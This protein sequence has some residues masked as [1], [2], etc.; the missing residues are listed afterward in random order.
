MLREQ[1][2]PGPLVLFVDDVHWLDETSA[3]LLA[4]LVDADLVFLVG[5]VRADE[6][7][8]PS[9]AALWL[10]ARVRRVDLG[11]LDKA[12]VDTLL[13][14]V[15]GGPVT[16]GTIA[17]IWSASRGN[18]LFVRELVLGALETGRLVDEHGVW[19][20]I[21]PL[22][23]TTRLLELVEARVGDLGP[24]ARAAL[25]V[26]AVWEPTS[27]RMLESVVDPRLLETLDRS[28]L[29]TT[30]ADGRRDLV[31]L[32]HP[33]YGEILR[34]R[35]PLLTR[36]RLLLDQAERIEALGARRRDDAMR[37]ASARVDAAAPADARLLLEAARLARWAHDYPQVERLARA[38][39][40]DGAAPEA[41]LLLGEALH[42]LGSFEEAERVLADAMQHLADADDPS[43]ADDPLFV[44]MT[45]LR[46]RT[47]MWGLHRRADAL[48][49]SRAA[50]AR[51]ADP[52]AVDELVLNEAIL[53]GYSGRPLDA[54]E[55]VDSVADTGTD[56]ARVRTL[57][58]LAEVPTL[59]VT[60]RPVTG[61]KRARDAFA[62]HQLLP[63]QMAITSP[64]VH[65]NHEIHALTDS[66]ALPRSV[67]DRDR[68]LPGAA[69][70][71]A[72]RH[73]DVAH[74]HHRPLH[75]PARRGSD[76][77]AV[78]GR[79]DPAVG[80]ARHRRPAP[81]RAVT[82]RDRARVARRRGSRRGR[83]RRA[84]DAPRARPFARR[85]GPRA[86]VG[87]RRRGRRARWTDDPARGGGGCRG[88]RPSRVGGMAPP[89]RRPP[90]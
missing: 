24:D 10:R 81:L 1:A 82:S 72:A 27:I 83:G 30:R 90:R 87:T 4:Q 42:E 71:D 18:L 21:G 69:P 19:Q 58:A 68:G 73:A 63:Q 23:T 31:S 14:L 60:G 79:D 29:L 44:L 64:G 74:P 51:C 48:A 12:G 26:L 62:A 32:A 43:G 15:L 76:R 45:E 6:P 7:V 53:L 38:A 22:F 85:A 20:L 70:D 89:R 59:I 37:V 78:A 3:T 34:A 54:L 65:L 8:S 55:L 28:G 16:P 88:D 5:T 86:G 2:E 25:D 13:H 57:R 40:L 11:E 35:M 77:T 33:L 75:A 84:A 46:A 80:R 47:L 39:V 41:G 52:A 36:R 17:A 9:L 56:S 50:H 66:G 49:V 61:A 67:V